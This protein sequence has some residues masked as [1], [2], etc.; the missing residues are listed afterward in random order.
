LQFATAGFDIWLAQ[1]P[2]RL[3]GETAMSFDQKAIPSA[4]QRRSRPCASGT[5]RLSLKRVLTRWLGAKARSQ[6]PARVAEADDQKAPQL[7]KDPIS[8]VGDEMLRQSRRDNQPLSVVVFEFRDLPELEYVF[9]SRVAKEAVAKI[10]AKLM[11]MA[12]SKGVARRTG[13]T[14]FTVLLPGVDCDS[15]GAGIRAMLGQTW[16]VEI[17]AADDDIV[18]VPEFMVRTICDTESLQEV[19][20][21]LCSD[22]RQLTKQRRQNSEPMELLAT[23]M[24][25]P[26]PRSTKT[27]SA[28]PATIPMPVGGSG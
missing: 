5:N 24:A 14:I 23:L 21:G 9:G 28:M 6:P 12:T 19:H 7:A 18:L 4:S 2:I 11:R 16:C 26:K 20:E 13:P 15:A 3:S 27:S 17:E 8:K 25:P 1:P 10:T 22:L